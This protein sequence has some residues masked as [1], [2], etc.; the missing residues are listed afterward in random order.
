MIKGPCK[1]CLERQ[2]G[3]H[4]ICKKYISYKK[5]VDETNSKIRR[6]KLSNTINFQLNEKRHKRR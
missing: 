6:L 5:E 3:C 1:D 2:L 4:S